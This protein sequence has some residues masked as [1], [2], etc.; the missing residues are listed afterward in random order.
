M[1]DPDQELLEKYCLP[2]SANYFVGKTTKWQR[3]EWLNAVGFAYEAHIQDSTPYV[4]IFF[5][6][7]S[8]V[9]K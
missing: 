7:S 2:I 5:T 3:C 1:H 8:V 9:V 6:G 4:L